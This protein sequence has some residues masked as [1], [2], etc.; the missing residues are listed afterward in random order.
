MGS[1]WWVVEGGR[2]KILLKIM[3]DLSWCFDYFKYKYFKYFT[4]SPSFYYAPSSEHPRS[5]FIPCDMIDRVLTQYGYPF[6]ADYC[7]LVRRLVVSTLLSSVLLGALLLRLWHGW[8]I[9]SVAAWGMYLLNARIIN[10]TP[11]FYV[12]IITCC[13]SNS[14][15]L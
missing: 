1:G 2:S 12:Y 4:Y 15:T 3:F 9:T 8:I 13:D 11:P 6:P 7:G 14:V 10:Y 5:E